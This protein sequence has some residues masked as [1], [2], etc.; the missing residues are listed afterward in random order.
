M[1]APGRRSAGGPGGPAPARPPWGARLEADGFCVLRAVFSPAEVAAL[2]AAFARL[3]AQAA[4]LPRP[5]PGPAPAPA[6]A[7]G[8]GG[9]GG[10]KVQAGGSEFVLEG[11]S[12]RRV[13]WAGAAEP[14][15]L[16]FGRDPRLLAVVR[17]ALGGPA[18]A[19]HLVCQAHFKLPG[20]GTWFPLH[21]DSTHRGHGTP[22]W[23][24]VNGRGSYVQTLVAVD[25]AT[26][27]N[28]PVEF[29]RGS[30]REGHLGLPYCEGAQTEDPRL[31]AF[32]ADRCAAELAP[33]DV[34]VFG[35][36]VVHGSQPNE[37]A[38]PRRA[39]VNGFAFPGANR[40]RYPGHA[41]G[42]GESVDLT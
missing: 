5:P 25:A 39:F 22:D 20:D 26:R 16:R 19:D 10:V 6:P 24:D 38:S 41:A 28:G 8:G 7:S 1:A 30:H 35:P 42:A 40:K 12:L 3:E 18:R 14:E 13:A 34:A 17:E 29:L 32:L 4:G 33:G 11:A 21:Q 23:E 9:A 15:L 36:Y 37:S 27:L 2:A 31:G